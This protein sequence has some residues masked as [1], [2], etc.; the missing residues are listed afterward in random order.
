MLGTA[1]GRLDRAQML[2][3]WRDAV[4]AEIRAG[5]KTIPDSNR[6]KVA[7]FFYSAHELWTEGADAWGGKDHG[8]LRR[9]E[10]RSGGQKLA[11][12][13]S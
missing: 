3:D 4:W 7:Y 5:I 11:A 8:H 13:Q 6:P 9:A 10:R 12:S 1:I 2:I